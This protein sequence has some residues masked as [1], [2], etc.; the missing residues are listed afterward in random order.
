MRKSSP[1][2]NVTV[3]TPEA[4]LDLILPAIRQAVAEAKPSSTKPSESLAEHIPIADRILRLKD[5]CQI[6][7]VSRHTIA[8]LEREGD[9]PQRVAITDGVF[10]YRGSEVLAWR[11]ARPRTKPA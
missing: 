9:F 8:D 5:T 3:I 6:A 11:D 1:P 7:G 4:F 2:P 10:G